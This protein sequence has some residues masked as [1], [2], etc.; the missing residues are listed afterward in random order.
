MADCLRR[1]ATPAHT[2]QGGHTRVIP[3]AHDA[4]LDE[5]LEEA[6]AEDGV[7]YI[8]PGEFDLAGAE[9]IQLV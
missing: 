9:E 1:I 5:L 7:G 4:L 8:Q 6:L 2:A 3:A